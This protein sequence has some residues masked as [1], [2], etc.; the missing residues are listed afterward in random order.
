[1]RL[2]LCVEK[3]TFLILTLVI[4]LI[5]FSQESNSGIIAGNVLDDKGKAVQSATVELIKLEDSLQKQTILTD[6]DGE[7]A[8]NNIAFG[9][10]RLRINY[11]GMQMLNI[12]SIHFRTERFDFNLSDLTLKP[13][14]TENL[15]EVIIYAEKP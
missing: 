2:I 3:I 12:D 9:Y 1:M 4:G 13:K 6:K 10:Y 7:F 8:I 5:S 15:G 14:S 11:V